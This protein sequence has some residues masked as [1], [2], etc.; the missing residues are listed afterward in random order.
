VT[1]KDKK[2]MQNTFIKRINKKIYLIKIIKKIK[3]QV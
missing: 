2:N 1:E 3:Y